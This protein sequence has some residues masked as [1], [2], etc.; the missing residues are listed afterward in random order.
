M[1][2]LLIKIENNAIA[3]YGFEN[4]KTIMI[5]KATDIVRKMLRV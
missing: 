5:F 3:S 2:K 4:K 1:S